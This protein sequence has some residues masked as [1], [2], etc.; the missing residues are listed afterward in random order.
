MKAISRRQF[1]QTAGVAMLVATLPAL[2]RG[3]RNRRREKNIKI[4]SLVPLGH[5][6][7]AERAFIQRARFATA[8]DAMR[9][10][11]A[12]RMKAEIYVE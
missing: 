9:A 4:R 11:A 5:L 10:V 8:A 2:G 7:P 6:T 1:L 12:R 3:G